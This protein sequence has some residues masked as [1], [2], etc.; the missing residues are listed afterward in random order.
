[1]GF[2]KKFFKFEENGATFSKE[3]IAGLT[4]FFAMVYII[5][6]NPTILS[7]TGMPWQGVF[8][9]TIFATIIGTLIMG[10]FANVPYA[11]APGMG[12][13][14]LFAY[15][16]A[17][18]MGFSWQEALAIVFISGILNIIITVTKVRKH[19]VLSIPKPL[20]A[21]IGGAIG[22][23]IA[24]IG[25]M[26]AGMVD[27]SGIPFGGVPELATFN[28]PAVLVAVIG[29]VVTIVLLLLKVPGAILIGII[30]ATIVGIPMGVSDI[31]AFKNFSFDLA[32]PFQELG[33]TSFALFDGFGSMFSNIKALPMILLAVFAFSLSDTFDTIGTFIGTGRQTGIFTDEDIEA[34]EHSKGFKTKMEKALFA[35]AIATSIG[36][37]LGTSN[38][39][40]Y[41]ESAAGIEAG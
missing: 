22:L 24:Y 11:V 32:T 2:I 9:A 14:A 35:D 8:L 4:T 28:N 20:Q 30:F 7:S 37:L 17:G 23:F 25:M 38:T 31:S 5:F 26:N 41:V 21:A 16:V 12:L 34:V 10:L 6:V 29:L 39:T 13:N 40:T 27:F 15:T 33:Q 1:M 18:T 36:A 3:I 19:I